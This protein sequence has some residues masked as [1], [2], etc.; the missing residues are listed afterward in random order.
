[1]IVADS[2][3]KNIPRGAVSGSIVELVL[4]G[5]LPRVWEMATITVTQARDSYLLNAAELKPL[6]K[7]LQLEVIETTRSLSLFSHAHAL[8]N[9][10]Y[11]AMKLTSDVGT[12][13]FRMSNEWR[14]PN[15]VPK[16]T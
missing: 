16:K 9:L 14:L 11:L 8:F 15:L 10:L 1:M 5:R 7:P 6:P 13:V 12:V 2:L 3:N 4:S